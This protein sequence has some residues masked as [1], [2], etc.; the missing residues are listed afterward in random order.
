[1]LLDDCVS[2]ILS[3]TLPLDACRSLSVSSSFRS[4]ANSD[5]VWESL[6]PSDYEDIV[7]RSVTPLKFSSKKE[8]FVCLC[9]PILTDGGNKVKGSLKLLEAHITWHQRCS[10]GIADQNRYLG[11]RAVQHSFHH[12]MTDQE[13][14]EALAIL[15]SSEGF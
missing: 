5:I 15:V 4:A 8:I 13:P 10:S 14:S 1:M 6:L 11:T 12:N 9:D 2:T 3:N 7:S